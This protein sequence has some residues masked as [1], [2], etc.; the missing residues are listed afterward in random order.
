MKSIIKAYAK[1]NL[2]LDITGRQQNGYHTLNTVMQQI[3]LY[4]EV[5]VETNDSGKFEI[6]C[7]N[8]LI[9][10]DERNIAFKACKIF[11]E[12][13]GIKFGAVITIKKN[14]PLEAGMGGSSTDGAAVLTALNNIYEVYSQQYLAENLGAKLGADVPFCIMGGTA[15]CTGIGDIMTPV[16]CSKDYV[17]AVIKPDFSCNTAVAYKTYDEN[18]LP[19]N[20]NFDSFTA[21]LN[22]GCEKWGE[23]MYNVFEKLYNNPKITE[24]TD[25][26]KENG[27]VNAILTGS[28]SAVFGLF[29]SKNVAES[30]VD[31]INAPFKKIVIPL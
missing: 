26:L 9:P 6:I 19:V 30:A 23:G 29:R 22:R 24:I 7:N 31:K 27:A 2:F 28:G 18:Q 20:N 8:P 3:D 11:S 5:Q 17:I 4:D 21:D 15:V 12:Y 13:S 14:I 25:F 1:V 10:C 16:K